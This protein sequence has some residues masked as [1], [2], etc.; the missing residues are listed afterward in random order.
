MPQSAVAG[1]FPI[2]DAHAQLRLDPN[3]AVYVGS[4]NAFVPAVAAF[5]RQVCKRAALEWFVPVRWLDSVPLEK[6]VKKTGFF[7][8]QNTVCQ[9]M[10]PKW[11]HTFDR[12]K[13]HFPK[14]NDD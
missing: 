5:V 4:G 12:L 11:R 8:N 9:P 10:T 7:G 6:A 14:W 13:E 1:P 3:K 2:F